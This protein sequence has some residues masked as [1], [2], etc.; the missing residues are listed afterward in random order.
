MA[1]A[2][3]ASIGRSSPQNPIGKDPPQIQSGDNNILPYGPRL[4]KKQIYVFP[5]MIMHACSDMGT[6]P[7]EPEGGSGNEID[8]A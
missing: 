7:V 4:H 6:R 1:R 8:P 5:L 2:G 3:L